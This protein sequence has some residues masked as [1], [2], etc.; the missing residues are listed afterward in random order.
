[1]KTLDYS[2]S[3]HNGEEPSQNRQIVTAGNRVHEVVGSHDHWEDSHEEES[4]M[5]DSHAHVAAVH[6]LG[7]LHQDN[8]WHDKTD[9][10]AARNLALVSL[11]DIQYHIGYNI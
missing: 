5:K 6:N 11:I 1:L 9:N 7:L 10:H 8:L 4:N 2:T 3:K